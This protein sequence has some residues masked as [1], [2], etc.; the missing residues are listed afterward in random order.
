[1]NTLLDDNKLLTLLS[2][3][4]IM[5]SSQVSILFGRRICPS[6][7]ATVSRA[8]MIYLN[9]EDLGW[10]PYATSWLKTYE[11]DEVFVETVREM[12]TKFMEAALEFRRLKC[13]QLVETDKLAAVR[14]FTTLFDAHMADPASSGLDKTD[15]ENYAS[16]LELTFVYCLVWSVGASL[17]D[18]SRK[19]FDAFVRENDNRVPSKDT[20]YE[21][22]VDAKAKEWVP[23]ESKLTT[24]RPP[25][26]CRFSE[27]VPT[28]DTLRTKTVALTLVGVRAH[29]L[30]VGNVGVGKTMVAQKCLEELPEGRSSCVI[31]FPRKPPPTRCRT[32]SRV[33]SRSVARVRSAPAAGRKWWSCATT[34]TCPRNP[35]LGSCPRWSS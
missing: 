17:D 15:A 10:W 31:N 5:M 9:V 1:M 7:P 14:Q 28:V 18:E 2:G 23:W 27:S 35:S 19:K 4:R 20:V 29:V 30:V 24:Y 12:L 22:F 21:Y 32:L 13:K 8:G 34:S 11:E 25:R 33:N 16:M 26:G 6:R 3:E